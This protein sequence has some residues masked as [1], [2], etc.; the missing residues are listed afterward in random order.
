MRYGIDLDGVLGDFGAQVVKIGNQLWPGK[1]PPGYKPDNWNYVGYLS[2]AEW[3]EVWKAID[4]TPFFWE[5]ELEE[6]LGVDDIKRDLYVKHLKDEVFFVTAR[7]TTVGEPPAVQSAHRLEARGLYPR[8]G[9]STVLQVNDA[10][11]KQDLFRGLKLKYMLDDYAPTVVQLQA[12]EGMHAYLL[13]QPWNRYEKNVPRVY[14]VA[15]YLDTIH[16]L[17]ATI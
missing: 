1:F 17:D 16:K 9:Y 15:E 13:D 11:Y 4:A 5:N 8:N 12:I 10:K 14:S 3:Q 2:D 7:R 6:G